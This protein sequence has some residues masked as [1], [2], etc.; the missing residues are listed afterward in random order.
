MEKIF[1]LVKNLFT[2]SG[3]PLTAKAAYFLQAYGKAVDEESLLK[4]LFDTIRERILMK[5][6]EGS[7]LCMIEVNPEITEYIPEIIS[8]YETL[9]YSV[10]EINEN[11]RINGKKA[12]SGFSKGSILI[13]SWNSID[14][15]R[16][17]AKQSINEQ[18]ASMQLES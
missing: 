1:T 3:K 7:S 10:I 15:I 18:L 6:Q 12:P 13:I 2:S 11:S 17:F 16:K 8:R 4:E 14:T 5:S 9:G